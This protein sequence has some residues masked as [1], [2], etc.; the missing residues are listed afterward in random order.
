LL[1]GAGCRLQV[2]KVR[3]ALTC[4]LPPAID[5]R[6]RHRAYVQITII[7]VYNKRHWRRLHEI[8]TVATSLKILKS[9]I[10][11]NINNCFKKV[12]ASPFLQTVHINFQNNP[13]LEITYNQNNYTT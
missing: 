12:V 2:L 9:F 10:S 8:F 5:T 1:L 4:F 3:V 13:H 7:I 6:T 11:C